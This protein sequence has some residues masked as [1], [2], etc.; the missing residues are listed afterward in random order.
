MLA[1][2]APTPGAAHAPAGTG[3]TCFVA[4][5]EDAALREAI[6]GAVAS[7]G[8]A[9][10]TTSPQAFAD[11]LVAQP[12][13]IAILDLAGVSGGAVQFIERLHSQFPA[14]VL[15]AAGGARDQA[16]LA[17]LVADGTVCRFAHRPVSSQRLGL[18]LD[19]ALRRREALTH[20]S[21]AV[22]L[23]PLRPSN[24]HAAR[25]AVFILLLIAAAG[26]GVWLL[27][28]PASPAAAVP[29]SAAR[30]DSGADTASGA[31]DASTV[32]AASAS[33]T[34]PAAPTAPASAP[35]VA[36]TAAPL[37]AQGTNT[38]ASTT[39]DAD[40]PVA[41]ARHEA[42]LARRLMDVGLLIDPPNNSARSHINAA[43]RL[44]PDDP[45]VRR[46]ARALSGRLVN[47]ARNALLTEDLA[48]AQRWVDAARAYGVNPATLA[49][50]DD[51]L[52]M[53]KG[54]MGR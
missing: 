43:T 42:Q 9:I 24:P 7:R 15:V 51:Q 49:E 34:A 6:D 13:G 35:A 10:V 18:F 28:R 38:G 29:A 46:T 1:E 5:C 30:I 11:A 27:R 39:R 21:R 2:P 19:A 45:E 36:P 47:A 32:R 4:L 50:L 8:H 25:I 23:A 53:L 17:P 40:D 22:L 31:A 16:A 26:T 33:P 44:A 14:L 37:P 48:G 52:A 54:L 41:Q 3:T 20:E 12:D